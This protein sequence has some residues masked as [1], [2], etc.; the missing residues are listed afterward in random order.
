[1]FTESHEFSFFQVSVLCLRSSF[2]APVS[3]FNLLYNAESPKVLGNS[4]I[5]RRRHKRFVRLRSTTQ[6]KGI[7]FY[8]VFCFPQT[9]FGPHHHQ[10]HHHYHISVMQL[11]HSLTRSGFTYPEVSSEVCQIPSASK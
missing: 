2:F 8:R 10:N 7:L 4:Q 3:I 5:L 6:P 1:M 11:G 9:L